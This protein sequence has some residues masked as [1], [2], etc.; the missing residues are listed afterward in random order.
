MIGRAFTSLRVRNFRL[1]MAGQLISNVGTWCQAVALGWLVYTLTG[2][3]TALGTV[4]AVQFVPALFLSMWGG[5]LADRFDKR[6]LLLATQ[7]AQAAIAAVLAGLVL[8][9]TI[10]DWEVYVLAFLLGAATAVDMPT[11]GS[12]VIEMVGTDEVANGVALNSVMVNLS[13]VVG[14]ALAGLLIKLAGLGWCFTFNAVSFAAVIAALAAMR[15][16]ELH[17]APAPMRAKRQVREGLVYAWRT[18]ELRTVLLVVAVVGTFAMNFPVVLAVLAKRVFHGG[19]GIY[20]VLSVV[21]A[22][23]SVGGAIWVAIR[24][25]PTRTFFLGSCIAFGA[26]TL[27]AGLSTRIVVVCAML[28]V[29]G[30]ASIMMMSTAN[31]SLQVN[32][33]SDMR[34]RVAALY[35]LVFLGSVP[36]GSPVIGWICQH[37]GADV[38]LVL[39]GGI[40]AVAGL[41]ALGLVRGGKRSRTVPAEL[42]RV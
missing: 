33:R 24:S 30:A 42:A 27:A 38:G 14:P 6:K 7:T 23:G 41:V 31:A 29:A 37:W 5:L 21:L 35:T 4:T 20:S 9:H 10:A 8:S 32:S 28:G 2:S 19:P 40:T 3:G 25:R 17:S 36:I 34:G 15:P 39:S 18:P 13:R 26:F 1:F 12:F 11:R 22:V 16:G